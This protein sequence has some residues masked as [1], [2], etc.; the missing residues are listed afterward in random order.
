MAAVTNQH[1]S[2]DRRQ[3]GR[4]I[5]H[6]GSRDFWASE[7]MAPQFPAEPLVSLSVVSAGR[8]GAKSL[9]QPAPLLSKAFPKSDQTFRTLRLKPLC[10]VTAFFHQFFE[11]FLASAALA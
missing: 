6:Q 9:L 5:C 1:H 10:K 2:W 11:S 3:A 8:I 7:K 4:A